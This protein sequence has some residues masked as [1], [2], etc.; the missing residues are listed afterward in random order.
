MV[1]QELLVGAL[2]PCMKKF[3]YKKYTGKHN[4]L[5]CEISSDYLKTPRRERDLSQ[6]RSLQSLQR[7]Y[8]DFERAG[9]DIRKAKDYH[10]VIQP[11]FFDIP[12]N[13]VTYPAYLLRKIHIMTIH[14]FSPPG[15]HITLGIY[16]HLF[17]LL[18]TECHK[19]DCILAAHG[20]GELVGAGPSFEDHV[21]IV[22]ER[23]A[24][25]EVAEQLQSEADELEGLVTWFCIHLENA[26]TNPQLQILRNEV[27][28]KKSQREQVVHTVNT[29]KRHFVQNCLL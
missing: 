13:Q 19:L 20:Q 26:E 10:N 2:N 24:L 1:S 23:Q 18:E 22:K 9:G 27:S 15:L 17:T 28:M 3:K 14:N 25:R 12:L 11:H 6:L 16:Y 8:S 7:D 29:Y 21:A 5:W 4:C